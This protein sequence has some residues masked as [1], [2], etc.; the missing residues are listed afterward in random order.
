MRLPGQKRHLYSEI[1]TTWKDTCTSGPN[2]QCSSNEAN[3]MCRGWGAWSPWNWNYLL[4]CFWFWKRADHQS[5]VQSLI[6]VMFKK[7]LMALKR[8]FFMWLKTKL[9]CTTESI[10]LLAKYKYFNELWDL[11]EPLVFYAMQHFTRGKKCAVLWIFSFT[12]L[13]QLGHPIKETPSVCLTDT[14]QWRNLV[15]NQWRYR[16]WW[17]SVAPPIARTSNHWKIQWILQQGSIC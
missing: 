10:G 7:R 5:I 2:W 15:A 1:V 17:G 14:R 13:L 9:L 16:G 12:P 8:R 6:K 11:V 3:V 4:C